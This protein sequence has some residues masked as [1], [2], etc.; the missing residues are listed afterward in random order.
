MAEPARRGP[1][2]EQPVGAGCVL[3]Q[4][5][6]ALAR[7]DDHGLVV[8]AAEGLDRARVA[9]GAAVVRVHLEDVAVVLGHAV[10][11]RE[12]RA[13][14]AGQPGA[15][16]GGTARAVGGRTGDAH[17]FGDLAAAPDLDDRAAA[18][19]GRVVDEALGVRDGVGPVLPAA[20]ELVV[21]DEEGDPAAAL[22]GGGAVVVGRGALAGLQLRHPAVGDHS[23]GEPGGEREQS[24]RVGDEGAV[25][26]LARAALLVAPRAV[27]G[28]QRPRSGGEGCDRPGER[29][30]RACEDGTGG[31]VSAAER[32]RISRV[33]RWCACRTVV[34]AHAPART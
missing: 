32:H 33:G 21:V 8:V 15:P 30:A 24:G 5:G 27:L 20:P 6:V 16:G 10:P 7:V 11:A 31:E 9:V 19:R 14:L 29:D 25:A 13:L 28:R 1:A 17:P 18:R 12:V 26:G 2:V 23:V 34:G 3:G 22:E 4:V